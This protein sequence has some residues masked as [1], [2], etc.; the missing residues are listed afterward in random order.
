MRSR[1]HLRCRRKDR[2]RQ[3]GASEGVCSGP[4]ALGRLMKSLSS[5]EEETVS[6]EERV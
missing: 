1:E 2:R 4:S 3:A 6:L 5:V